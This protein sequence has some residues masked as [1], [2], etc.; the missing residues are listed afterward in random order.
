MLSSAGKGC[1]R[2]LE[3]WCGA[4]SIR[5]NDTTV[6]A[7]SSFSLFFMLPEPT[8]LG[9]SEITESA[10]YGSRLRGP[11]VCPSSQT[12]GSD[13]PNTSVCALS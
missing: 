4:E 1:Q 9:P 8:S 12:V 10:G 11:A 2:T 7:G 13:E 3:G 5:G 6:V